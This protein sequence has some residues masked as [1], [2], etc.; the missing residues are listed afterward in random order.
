MTEDLFH[1]GPCPSSHQHDIGF[2]GGDGGGT[3][4]AL[5]SIA[6]P[7]PSAAAA[8]TPAAATSSTIGGIG[9]S[10]A[11]DLPSLLGEYGS[12]KLG[13]VVKMLQKGVED[14]LEVSAWTGDG[15]RGSLCTM[16][17][18]ALTICF[19]SYPWNRVQVCERQNQQVREWDGRLEVSAWE[20]ETWGWQAACASSSSKR[21]DLFFDFDSVSSFPHLSLSAPL[22]RRRREP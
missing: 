4:A 6:A 17:C 10:T 11:A 21:E 3:T 8:A 18:C 1:L 2:G 15:G 16:P 14:D 9:G 13:E 12:M 5:A 19:P 22:V 7:A 20:G